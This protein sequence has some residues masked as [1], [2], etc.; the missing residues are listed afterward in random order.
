LKISFIRLLL[1][2]KINLNFAQKEFKK[3]EPDSDKT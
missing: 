1:W 2:D 3:E